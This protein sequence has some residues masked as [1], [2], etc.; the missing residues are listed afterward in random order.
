MKTFLIFLSFINTAY[1]FELRFMNPEC[2]VVKIERDLFID[3]VV[4][5]FGSSEKVYIKENEIEGVATGDFLEQLISPIS[6][7]LNLYHSP[8]PTALPI[9]NLKDRIMTIINLDLPFKE[10]SVEWIIPV[11][12]LDKKNRLIYKTEVQQ[13]Y[14]II[15]HELHIYKG[16]SLLYKTNLLNY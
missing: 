3:C 15:D 16:K 12:I 13:K 11:E 5:V 10:G 1:C 14:L 8:Y 6:G 4:S 7:G 2:S 9:H